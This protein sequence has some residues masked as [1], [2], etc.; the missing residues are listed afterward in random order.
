[1]R[2]A[3][4]RARSNIALVKYWGKRDEKRILPVTGSLSLTLDELWTETEVRFTGAPG[5][6]ELVIGGTRA[7]EHEHRRASAL[8][9]LVRDGRP[10]LGAARIDSTTS[11]PVAAGLASSAS[12][13]AA[14]AAAA[15]WAAGDD[16]SDLQLSILARRASGSACRSVFGGFAEW[17]RGER[18][19]G[20][21]SHGVQL[22]GPDE[23]QVAMAI[24]EVEAGR[25]EVSS[26]HAMRTARE[27]SPYFPAWEAQTAIDLEQAREAIRRRDLESLGRVAERS[28]FAMHATCFTSEPPVFFWKPSTLAVLEAVRTLRAEGVAAYATID[29]GPHVAVLCEAG[30]L[31]RVGEALRKVDGVRR[32]LEARPGPGVERR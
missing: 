15:A 22:L 3:R 12:G 4:A 17:R 10:E 23:W 18:E 1:M 28:A 32:V 5:E 20:A 24:A 19:D 8:L 9:D 7:T 30:Q 31:G 11:F 27:T 29:A 2:T 26:R 25:K 16:P 13:F 21:D 6:D 14:L